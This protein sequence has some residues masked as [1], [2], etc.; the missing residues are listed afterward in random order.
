MPLW[1]ALGEQLGEK[2]IEE[3]LV[4]VKENSKKVADQMRRNSDCLP[5]SSV[6]KYLGGLLK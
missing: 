2:K 6:A 5:K 1:Q 3:K 4:V